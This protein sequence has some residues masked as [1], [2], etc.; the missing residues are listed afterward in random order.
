MKKRIVIECSGGV[1]TSVYSGER[2]I[3]V[4]LVDWDNIEAGGGVSGMRVAAP[5]EIPDD[6]REML[7]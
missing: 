7:E 3:E 6:T 5:S 4:L 1:V 2:D